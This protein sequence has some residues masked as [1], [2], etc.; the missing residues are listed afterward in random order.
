VKL[1]STGWNNVTVMSAGQVDNVNTIWARVNIGTDAGEILS[2]P[3][4]VPSGQV[5]T[6]NAA[7]PGT[8]PA[9]TSGTILVNG[10]GSAI[11]VPTA[12]FPTVTATGPL[13]ASAC[14]TAAGDDRGCPGF[15]AQDTSGDEFYFP[16]QPTTTAANALSGTSQLVGD[17]GGNGTDDGTIPTTGTV[18]LPSNPGDFCKTTSVS[19]AG[20]GWRIN[21]DGTVA[22]FYLNEGASLA[23]GSQVECWFANGMHEKLVLQG[24][25]GNL[26][27]YQYFTPHTWGASTSGMSASVANFQTDGNFVVRNTSG[28]AIWASGTHTYHDAVLV[29]QAD[30]NLVI[31]ASPSVTSTALWSTGTS[32]P[33]LR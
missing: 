12:A 15:F 14:P 6:L 31:Y 28:G 22:G 19:N 17:V 11:Q 5:P 20:G 32:D 18:Q 3:L 26:V 10:S 4:T 27:F 8:L 1:G 33:S 25:D 16:G 30:G 9:A 21:T 2:F 13:S 23:L 24:S 29:I 7:A